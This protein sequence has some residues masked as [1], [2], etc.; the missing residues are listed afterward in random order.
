ME[1][2]E[3]DNGVVLVSAKMDEKRQKFLRPTSSYIMAVVQ[4]GEQRKD[5]KIKA[6]GRAISRAVDIAEA[7]AHKFSDWKK[8]N[9]EK[10]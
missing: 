1:K 2:R 5:V 8:G 9:I 4:Q 6:R 3:L 10:V 7:V